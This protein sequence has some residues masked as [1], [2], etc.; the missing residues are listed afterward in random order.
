MKFF[1]TKA[2]RVA[3]ETVP[4]RSWREMELIDKAVTIAIFGII[5]AVIVGGYGF[6]RAITK[7]RAIIETI[8]T[9]SAGT[10]IDKQIAVPVS[11]FALLGE[12]PINFLIIISGEVECN[13]EPH[14]EEKAFIV[15]EEVYNRYSV[16][17][18]FD[19]ENLKASE[20]QSAN[21]ETEEEK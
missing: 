12:S 13:D 18:W 8:S 1:K 17:E 20:Q 11:E 2:N 4:S 10:V 16:G 15:T 5:M 19:S 14:V 6:Y 3:H 9:I 7:Q 21:S